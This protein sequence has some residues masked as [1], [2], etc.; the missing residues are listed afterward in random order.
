MAAMSSLLFGLACA[1]ATRFTS[2][3]F[4]QRSGWPVPS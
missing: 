4:F 3:A 1:V 2:V